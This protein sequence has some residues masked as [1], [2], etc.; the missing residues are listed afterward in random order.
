MTAYRVTERSIATKVL[1]GLQ[2]NLKRMGD[3]EAQ[4]SSGKLISKPSDSPTGTVAA[5]QYRS[6]MAATKQYSRNSDDALGWLGTVDGSVTTV[7][8]QVMRVR[9]LVLTGMSSGAGGSDDARA[10]LAAEADQLRTSTLGVAN[11][12]YLDRPVFGGT[13]AGGVAFDATGSYVG[14]NG[15]VQRTVGDNARVPVATPG[16]DFFGT[17]PDQL[18]TVMASVANNLRT[19]PA[20]LSADLERLD[21]AMKTLQSAQSTAGARYNQVTQMQQA[22]NDRLDALEAQLSEVEDIDLPKTI[23]SMKMQETSYQAALAAGA[24]VV[25]P[26]LVDFLR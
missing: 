14:D 13:T 19:N 1:V 16:T 18:F 17:G 11:T 8:S 15:V 25:Q 3:I 12:K 20:G 21:A 9:D 26:S 24:K 10:A 23:I 4:L 6:E 7:I 5:M 22:A 2:G